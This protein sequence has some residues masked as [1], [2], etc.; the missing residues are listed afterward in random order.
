[1]LKSSLNGI[2]WSQ[3][4]QMT[5]WGKYLAIPL[6][7]YIYFFFNLKQKKKKKTQWINGFEA[8]KE[9]A[10]RMNNHMKKMLNFIEGK[11]KPFGLRGKHFPNR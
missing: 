10:K 7:I 5:N 6:N 4:L 8:L 11:L 3:K 2:V 1:M 9:K